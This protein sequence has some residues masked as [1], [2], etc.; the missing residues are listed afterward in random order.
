MNNEKKHTDEWLNW[1]KIIGKYNKPSAAKSWWQII[2]SVVPYLGLW[3]LMI[4]SLEI[5]YWLTLALAVLAAG[6]LVRIFIIFHDCGHGSFFKSPLLSRI[7]SIFTGMFV[8]T[9]HYKWHHEHHIHH[10]SVGNLDKRGVGDV[11]TITVEEYKN[12]SPGKQLYYRIYRHPITLFI[13]A[14]FFL[15]TVAMRFPSKTQSFNSKLYTH[16]TT[17]ALVILV[18]LISLLIGFRTFLLIQIPVLLIAS[19]SG[20]WLFY[21]QHQFEDVIWERTKNWDYKVIAMEGSSYL[22]LPRVLQW[23]SGNIGFHHLHHLSP[24][25]PNYNLEKC[26]NENAIFQKEPLTFWPSI[27]SMKY[28]LWDEQKHKLVSFKEARLAT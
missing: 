27:Q 5:S 12:Y 1:T 11:K 20:V 17:I 3:V 2:N 24:K 28:R 25:I 10:Q 7:V 8:F 16:L 4:Y 14:P 21:V 26:I 6:F 19:I 22:K 18:Y 9:P 13:I 23:F 15:F